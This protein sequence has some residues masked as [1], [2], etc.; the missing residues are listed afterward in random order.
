MEARSMVFLWKQ[1]DSSCYIYMAFIRE[2]LLHWPLREVKQSCENNFGQRSISSLDLV[3]P[4]SSIS[5]KDLKIIATLCF[6]VSIFEYK[7]HE[8][9]NVVR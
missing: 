8:K 9:L 1:L 5:T 4:L 3:S 7:L 6:P 2:V